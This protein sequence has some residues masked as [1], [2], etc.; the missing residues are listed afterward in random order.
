MHFKDL[1]FYVLAFFYAEA[2][3][4]AAQAACVCFSVA[5]LADFWKLFSTKFLAKKAQMISNFLDYFEKPHS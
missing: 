5:R 1:L 3:A 4:T 2:T